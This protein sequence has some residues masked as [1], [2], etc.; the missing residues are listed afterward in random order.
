MDHHRQGADRN[1]CG[2]KRPQPFEDMIGTL[3]PFVI[4]MHAVGGEEVFDRTGQLTSSR[5]VESDVDEGVLE[6]I[7]VVKVEV[8]AA[9]VVALDDCGAMNFAVGELSE[10]RDGV[11]SEPVNESAVKEPEMAGVFVAPQR[12]GC[13]NRYGILVVFVVR[14]GNENHRDRD[15]CLTFGGRVEH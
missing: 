10:P 7:G 6:V 4:A 8:V 5:Q 9:V 13:R 1:F 12:L 2:L 14:T 3:L 11:V 15:P